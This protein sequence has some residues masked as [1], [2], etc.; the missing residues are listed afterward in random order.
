MI[1]KNKTFIKKYIDNLKWI[2]GV[3]S[4][5]YLFVLSIGFNV[6]KE[7]SDKNKLDFT[8]TWDYTNACYFKRDNIRTTLA[9]EQ[10]MLKEKK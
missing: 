5:S 9:Q 4:F 1:I 10:D 2:G 8:F 3:V 6:C 7:V